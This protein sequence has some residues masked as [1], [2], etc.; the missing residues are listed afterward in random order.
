MPK[1]IGGGR[2]LRDADRHLNQ[3]A[4]E[5]YRDARARGERLAP[6]TDAYHQADQAVHEALRGAGVI[7]RL[8]RG[9][10]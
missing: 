1:L 6:E 4:R 2:R 7:T 9:W 5:A 10:L 3:V 8:T